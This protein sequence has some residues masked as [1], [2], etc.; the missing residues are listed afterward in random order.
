MPLLQLKWPLYKCKVKSDT[1]TW[2]KGTC[3]NRAI[4]LPPEQSVLSGVWLWW[5]YERTWRGVNSR[6]NPY[7]QSRPLQCLFDFS[8]LWALFYIAYKNGNLTYLFS[9][10][11]SRLTDKDC[12]ALIYLKSIFPYSRCGQNFKEAITACKQV[13][14]NSLGPACGKYV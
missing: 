10:S 4:C 14:Y 5:I 1:N 2:L 9:Q 7:V 11:V 6:P 12:R 13:S 8:K 3:T